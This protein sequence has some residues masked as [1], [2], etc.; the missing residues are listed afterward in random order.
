MFG[1]L[2]GGALFAAVLGIA[3]AVEAHHGWSGYDSTNLLT[4]TGTVQEVTIE[5]PHGMLRLET[6]EKTWTIVLSPPSRM[7]R[8]GLPAEAIAVGDEVTV[9]GYAHRSVEDEFRAER[10]TVDG[11]TVELR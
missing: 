4:L 9:E 3:P 7:Q 1:S 2:F 6:P 8:R 10:I 5:N 11:L